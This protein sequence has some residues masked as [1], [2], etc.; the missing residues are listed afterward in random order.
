M[1]R[2]RLNILV[3]LG[4]AVVALLALAASLH[5]VV[6]QPGRPFRFDFM[7]PVL[8]GGGATTETFTV[9]TWLPIVA[10]LGLVGFVIAL[11][12]SPSL[13]RDL[14]RNL[15]AYLLMVLG[16]YLILQ[17]SSE[18]AMPVSRPPESA[19]AQGD[20]PVAPAPPAVPDLVR[21]PPEWL[22]LLL[23]MLLLAGTLTVAFFLIRR[24]LRKPPPA[25]LDLIVDEAREALDDLRSGANLRDTISRCYA[26]MVRVISEQRGVRRDATL[27][28]REFEQR[29]ITIGMSDTHIRRLTRLFEWVRYSSHAAG[30][31]E[32]Q[33]AQACLE[34]IIMSYGVGKH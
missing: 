10:A 23:T 21:S 11:I 4:V 24:M 20:I 15:P 14:L 2:S 33:E 26:E 31:K 29:L 8:S 25:R 32:E 19:P 30:P 1:T 18:R 7:M 3:L 6:L 22:V 16:L 34:A 13:R 28:P 5:N 9:P 12:V 17:G 27:T